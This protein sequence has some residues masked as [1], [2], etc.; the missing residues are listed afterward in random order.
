MRVLLAIRKGSIQ[1]ACKL[2]S[3]VVSTCNHVVSEHFRSDGRYTP[4]EDS[5][6]E[7]LINHLDVEKMLVARETQ[8]K[9]RKVLQRLPERDRKVLTALFLEERPK[10]AICEEFG[11]DRGY[12]RVLLHRA[13]NSFRGEWTLFP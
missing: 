2:G 9:V 7:H 4:L 3:F 5:H 13:K 12:L 8:E 10:D 6:L 11:I 1:E